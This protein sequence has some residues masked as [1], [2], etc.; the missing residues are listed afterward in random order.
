MKIEWLPFR[1][2]PHTILVELTNRCNFRC[3][4][5]GIWREETKTDFGLDH[6][7]AM[8]MQKAVR[9]VRLIGLT[10]GEP[11]C[12]GDLHDYYT[13]AR[14]Y[15]P[16]AHINISTNGYYTESILKFLTNAERSAPS[17]TI[18]YDGMKSHDAIRGMDGA[19]ERLWNTVRQI[20]KQFPKTALS[21]KLTITNE[22]HSELLD[23]ARQC[24]EHGIALRIK[25][26]EK[27]KCHQSRCTAE[28]EGPE[29]TDEIMNSIADQ[30]RQI[31]RLGIETN[32]KYLKKLLRWRAEAAGP[33]GCSARVLFAGIDGN[34]F[35]CRKRDPIGNLFRQ[36]LDEIWSS[37]AKHDMIAAM[38]NCRNSPFGLSFTHD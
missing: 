36:P 14:R 34:L 5:C 11:F 3:R 4:M 23:T 10:G 2:R 35:L 37:D 25:T 32:R 21:L 19:S 28:I 22:N 38:K 12:L 20:R 24:K 9:S 17:I 6:F 33:C 8:L 27:L 30:A 18:S 16:A 1:N 7:E 29:Y 26:L 13:L 31:L 15:A